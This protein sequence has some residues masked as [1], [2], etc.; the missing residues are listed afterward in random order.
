MGGTTAADIRFRVSPGY[1]LHLFSELS[2]EDRATLGSDASGSGYCGV[3]V[4]DL[5]ERPVQ[6]LGPEAVEAVRRAQSR[7]GQHAT[8]PV[9]QT[10]LLAGVLEGKLRGSWLTGLPA[11]SELGLDHRG[12][13][14]RKDGLEWVA[15]VHARR[16]GTE[17]PRATS[18]RLYFSNRIPVTARWRS[19]WHSPAAIASSLDIDRATPFPGFVMSDTRATRPWLAWH[20]RPA[21]ESDS[22]WSGKLYVS[23]LPNDLPAALAAVREVLTSSGARAI[24]VGGSA[25]ALLRPDKCVLYFTRFDDLHD[26]ADRLLAELAG[27]HG[28]GVPFTGSI[29]GSKLLSWGAD[30]PEQ[31]TRVGHVTDAS[32]RVWVCNRLA[33]AMHSAFD[34]PDD[35]LVW[36]YACLCLQG[37]GVDV[38]RWAPTELEQ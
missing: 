17:D 3:L 28:Q 16:C 34:C 1:R 37:L 23:P 5:G 7:E 15:F 38:H 33:A 26:C 32:W 13:R 10:L 29:K 22:S 14:G 35:D 8:D 27:M 31:G 36:D 19:R 21:A 24:K 6:V 9:V 25:P 20:R 2:D 11:M 12:R 30:P 4:D 18:S